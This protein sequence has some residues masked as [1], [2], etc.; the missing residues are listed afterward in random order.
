MWQPRVIGILFLVGLVFQAAP[1]FVALGA[2]LW[3]NAILPAF[4]PFDALYNRLV[5]IPKGVPS[6]T[7][8]PAPR[9]FAQAEAGT[10]ML[11][12]GLALFWE[13]NLFAYALEALVLASLGALIFGRFCQG[14]YLYFLI[15][16]Q[17]AFA[18]QTLPWSP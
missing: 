16:R 15:T 5:A 7:P 18:N 3:W 9:R 14:S 10:V 11:A 12:I 8:A 1:F 6:L 17:S 13:V 2:L 4:N